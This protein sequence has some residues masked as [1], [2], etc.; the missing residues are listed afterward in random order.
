MG[1]ISGTRRGST[2]ALPLRSRMSLAASSKFGPIIA[3]VTSNAPLTYTTLIFR[4]KYIITQDMANLKVEP[5]NWLYPNDTGGATFTITGM[6]L[7]GSSFVGEGQVLWGGSGSTTI[8][9]PSVCRNPSDI[10]LPSQF[11]LGIFPSGT[12]LYLRTLITAT[13]G[14][15]FG[16]S[17]KTTAT[18]EASWQYNS[19]TTSFSPVSG[20]GAINVVSGT[21]YAGLT[22]TYHPMLVGIRNSSTTPPAI[23]AVGDSEIDNDGDSTY[24]VSSY[25]AIACRNQTTP[26]SILT[27]SHGGRSQTQLAS[28]IEW[29]RAMVYCSVL[30]DDHGTNAPLDGPNSPQSQ[31]TYYIT[32]RASYGYQKIYHVGL[33]P[34]STNSLGLSSLISIGT[35]AT[36]TVTDTSHMTN[37]VISGCTGATTAYNGTYPVTI[38]DSTHFTYTFAGTGGITPT[39]TPIATDGW[40]TLYYQ[41][42]GTGDSQA[43]AFNT[44]ITTKVNDGTA[45]QINGQWSPTS[46]SIRDSSNSHYWK[47]N[48][49]PNAFTNDGLHMNP[50]G[51]GTPILACAT[52]FQTQLTT[53]LSGLI[54]PAT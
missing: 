31:L 26:V 33:Y 53:W 28:D 22:G 29:N 20:A 44:W 27:I 43:S 8:T 2:G 24:N 49:T 39:G 32:A 5:H 12:I 23:L 6:Y 48:G 18:G 14:T 36:G 54:E 10:I 13:A 11:G 1:A 17:C 16:G 15:N 38:V 4:S 34:Q 40:Q 35:T 21:D 47:V 50:N 45:S 30:I 7:E 9:Y 25:L 46:A 3:G 19:A 37:V 51:A 42:L 41:V 52:E